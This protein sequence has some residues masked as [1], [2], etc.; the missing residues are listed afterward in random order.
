MAD[1]DPAAV[2]GPRMEHESAMAR[3]MLLRGVN[4]LQVSHL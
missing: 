4:E 1:K 3:S 2:S